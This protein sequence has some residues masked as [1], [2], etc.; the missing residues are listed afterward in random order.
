MSAESPQSPSYDELLA[1]NAVLVARLEQAMARI[2]EVSGCMRTLTG[3]QHFAAIR[4]YTT[5][6]TR[7]GINIYNALH[8]A[9][10]GTPWTPAPA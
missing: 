1:L 9:L 7:H 8:Q 6:A 5:A 3:A 10:T 2:A 4:S